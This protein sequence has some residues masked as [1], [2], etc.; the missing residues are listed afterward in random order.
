[1][2]GKVTSTTRTLHTSVDQIVIRLRNVQSAAVV[3]A[4]ALRHQNSDRDADIASLLERSVVDPIQ[5]QIDRLREL[6]GQ[7]R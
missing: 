6:P 5:D 1:V 4:A 2:S 3:A 7:G